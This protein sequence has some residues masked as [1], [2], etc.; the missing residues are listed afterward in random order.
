MKP[1]GVIRINLDTSKPLDTEGEWEDRSNE[2]YLFRLKLAAFLEQASG[3]V[4]EGW[5]AEL[6][7]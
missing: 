1:Y 3:F 5:I 7:C 4:P 6:E 2:L